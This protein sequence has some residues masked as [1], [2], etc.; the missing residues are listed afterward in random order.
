M[1]MNDMAAYNLACIEALRVGWDW[2]FKDRG[3]SVTDYTTSACEHLRNAIDQAKQ[4]RSLGSTK[5]IKD[6]I[7]TDPDLKSIRS[8]REFKGV[9]KLASALKSSN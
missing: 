5:Q 6:G 8:S 3:N 1:E 7:Q 2:R 4:L 9:L